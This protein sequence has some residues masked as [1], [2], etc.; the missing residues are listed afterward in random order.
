[1]PLLNPA[2]QLLIDAVATDLRARAAQARA[3]S[4]HAR[5]AA[6]LERLQMLRSLDV[7]EM[8]WREAALAMI[9]AQHE[10]QRYLKTA[11]RSLASQTVGFSAVCSVLCDGLYVLRTGDASADAHA[12]RQAAAVLWRRLLRSHPDPLQA[13]DYA[14]VGIE[15]LAEWRLANDLEADL[16]VLAMAERAAAQVLEFQRLAADG[17]SPEAARTQL[18]VVTK[19]LDGLKEGESNWATLSAWANQRW[20]DVTQRLAGWLNRLVGEAETAKSECRYLDAVECVGLGQMLAAAEPWRTLLADELAELDG[21]RQ[22]VAPLAESQAVFEKLKVQLEGGELVLGTEEAGK[23]ISGFQVDRERDPPLAASRDRL[24]YSQRLAEVCQVGPVADDDYASTLYTLLTVLDAPP[25]V[26]LE[27]EWH[28]LVYRIKALITTGWERV[29]TLVKDLTEA[30]HDSRAQFVKQ[31]DVEPL[32]LTSF[33]WQARWTLHALSSSLAVEVVEAVGA[34]RAAV[35]EAAGLLSEMAAGPFGVKALD[36]VDDPTQAGGDALEWTRCLLQFRQEGEERPASIALP[37]GEVWKWKFQDAAELDELE[38]KL[39]L[40]QQAEPPLSLKER[41]AA[42]EA[43]LY[44]VARVLPVGAEMESRLVQQ[45]KQLVAQ[46]PGIG[47]K[48]GPT[49]DASKWPAWMLIGIVVLSL[50]LVGK[51]LW[52]TIH[53]LPT[54]TVIA[55]TPRSTDTSVYGAVIPST[56]LLLTPTFDMQERFEVELV[57]AP[58]AQRSGVDIGTGEVVALVAR[59]RDQD[60]GKPVVGATVALVTDPPAIAQIQPSSANTDNNGETSALQLT[61]LDVGNAVLR[62]NLL[63]LGS[64]SVT[65]KVRPVAEVRV[66][67]L[68][69]GPTRAGRPIRMA[70]S[71]ERY[72]VLGRSEDR[73]WWQVRLENADL[74]WISAT[75]VLVV[76]ATADVKEI[77]P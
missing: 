16:H 64:C 14:R 23:R 8:A 44:V 60:T 39:T 70:R 50:M 75:D 20:D 17:G 27:L 49:P 66:Y 56:L 25:L 4:Q 43:L 2:R 33:L 67:S 11:E 77:Q 46:T 15:V 48:V 35:D 28:W 32:R 69:R 5:T 61:A 54:P 24:D 57:F 22:Q 73:N 58:L 3:A 51:L 36:V 72:V 1:V 19:A 59:V 26:E 65:V 7:D 30:L 37:P 40:L 76:G 52:N 68:L 42:N 45:R 47:G 31:P 34:L 21:L 63:G 6:L 10:A 12:I 74:A 9:E 29:T 55:V 41:Q 71:G 38:Q 18:T 62:F 53:S 13:S